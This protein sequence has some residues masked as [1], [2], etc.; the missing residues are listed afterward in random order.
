[1]CVNLEL[2]I[3]YEKEFFT[4]NCM[5]QVRKT[6]TP[7]PVTVNWHLMTTHITGDD[8][9]I[10]NVSI[11]SQVGVSKCINKYPKKSTSRETK[12]SL[13]VVKMSTVHKLNEHIL[14]YLYVWTS[15]LVSIIIAF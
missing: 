5:C 6:M 7:R 9:V 8:H 12:H 2:C 10:L 15:F 14:C 3:K 11:W 1:M 13:T 4:L